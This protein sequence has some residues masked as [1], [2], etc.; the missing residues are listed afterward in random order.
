MRA[1]RSNTE[2]AFRTGVTIF[3]A[4]AVIGMYAS[5]VG[6]GN[7][8]GWFRAAVVFGL[9]GGVGMRLLLWRVT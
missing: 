6:I 9:S 1:R 5:A 2:I 4:V 8:W 7:G 3:F